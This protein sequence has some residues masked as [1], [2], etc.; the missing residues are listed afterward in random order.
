MKRITTK[1]L[2]AFIALLLMSP[3][4]YARIIYVAPNG[5]V[6]NDGSYD[7]PLTPQKASEMVI[8]GDVVIFKDGTY[9]FD[10]PYFI[11]LKGN[12]S[13]K[14]IFKAENK[15]KAILIGS[16]NS[17][18]GT[19]YA[20]FAITGC[21]NIS[22]DGFVV[23][24]D[25]GSRDKGSGILVNNSAGTRDSDFI[26]I[27]NCK[28]Y[29]NGGTGIAVQFSDNVLVESNICYDNATRA[30]NNGSGITAFQLKDGTN[31]G[32][33][34]GAII[35]N[36]ICYHNYCELNFKIGDYQADKPTD[37]NGILIDMLDDGKYTKRTLIENNLCYN[38]GGKGIGSYKSSNVR[39]MSNTVY[40]NNFILSKHY[41]NTAE[42]SLVETKGTH[43][44]VYNNVVVSNPALK[45]DYAMLFDKVRDGVYGN[46]LVGLVGKYGGSN[47]YVIT[48]SN[49]P[50]DKNTVKPIAD[51]T[52]PAF[53][54]PTKDETKANFRLKSNS[55]LIDKYKEANHPVTDLE[56]VK[57]PKGS[58]ADIGCYEYTSTTPTDDIASVSAPG[59][60]VVGENVVITVNYSATTS[61]DLIVKFQTQTSPYTTYGTTKVDVSAGSGKLATITIPISFN[62]PIAKDAY[63]FQVFLTTNGGKWDDRFDN[64]T[65]RNVDAKGS[66]NSIVSGSIYRVKSNWDSKYLSG[67]NADGGEVKV[68]NLNTNAAAQKWKLEQV[69]GSI[70]RLKCEGGGKYLRADGNVDGTDVSVKNLN[71][72][73]D[74]QK[75]TLEYLS[76]TTYR[77]KSNVAAV[78]LHAEGNAD[79]SNVS[80]KNL[81][82]EWG[83]Q[84]WTLELV[85]SAARESN[86]ASVTAA[87]VDVP[88]A[89]KIK[90]YPNPVVSGE[91]IMVQFNGDYK[92]A[93]IIVMDFMGKI[94]Y[95]KQVLGSGTYQIPAS[96]LPNTSVYYVL[97]DV[98]GGT[99]KFKILNLTK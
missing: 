69:S 74:S 2:T 10:K 99:Q 72:G 96:V 5:K 71:T 81:N 73:W 49:F 88:S 34:Y 94:V 23:T 82:T 52:Y 44:A 9:R 83:S 79:G 78:Y 92:T 75:W 26:E 15:H 90:V 30:E 76:G 18:G 59:S 56:Y 46:H 60:V 95:Q 7:K 55:P 62:T 40:H 38:N 25:S 86:A 42:I 93:N 54:N 11:F 31:T 67:G 70:Y 24:H 13:T 84:K 58:G 68:N 21:H 1:I 20:V 35:R 32:A 65:K 29:N 19:N 89:G 37:G 28:V 39:I 33:Y 80:V 47:G 22:I 8:A 4:L 66:P 14:T 41:D 77:I 43:D 85:S 27:M 6:D 45:K 97:V 61:R 17:D 16:N 91:A 64:V 51:Q 36:N 53:V 48:E 50:T 63:Q 57:R 3:L 98:V 87:A 12:K